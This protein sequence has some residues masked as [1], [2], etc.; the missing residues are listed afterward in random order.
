MSLGVIAS[1]LLIVMF[2]F[3]GFVLFGG[4]MFEDENQRV[5][6]M[7]IGLVMIVLVVIMPTYFIRVKG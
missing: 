2:I 7:I 4:I 6:V 1:I 3:L 5:T